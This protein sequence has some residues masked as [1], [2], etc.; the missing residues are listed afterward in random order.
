MLLPPIYEEVFDFQ[1][2]VAEAHARSLHIGCAVRGPNKFAAWF[3]PD[4][5]EALKVAGYRIVRVPYYTEVLAETPHQTLIGSTIPFR[6]F[7]RVPWTRV[8]HHSEAA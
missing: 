7:M 1:T 5:I 2:I 4:E 3:L 6:E 8:V